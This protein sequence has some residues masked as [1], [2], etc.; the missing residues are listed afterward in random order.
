VELADE[1]FND[2]KPEL[3]RGKSKIYDKMSIE[4]SRV[5]N[6]TFQKF[7]LVENLCCLMA[8]ISLFGNILYSE[9]DMKDGSYLEWFTLYNMTA[10]T[11]FLSNR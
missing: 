6:F 3:I 11:C 2:A 5:S 7:L 4:D 10:V 1:S 9:D 8:Y